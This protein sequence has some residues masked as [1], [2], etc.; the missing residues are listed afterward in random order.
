MK[1]PENYLVHFA[2]AVVQDD[3]IA[4]AVVKTRSRRCTQKITG[5]MVSNGYIIKTLD[6]SRA[7]TCVHDSK[8]KMST[9]TRTVNRQ[10]S[11]E[12]ALSQHT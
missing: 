6:M 8:E 10:G 7:D 2:K 9:Y 4:N 3:N 1:N 11:T 5:R 12:T